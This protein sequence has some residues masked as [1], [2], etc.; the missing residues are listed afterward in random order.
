[1]SETVHAT[2]V[3]VGASGV[4]IRGPSGAGKS[5][6]AWLLIDQGAILVADDRVHL[7]A[8]HGRLVGTVPGRLAGRLELRGRGILHMPFERSV[9][10]RLAVDLVADADLER[11]PNVGELRAQILGIELARQSVP[12]ASHRALTLIGAALAG[13]PS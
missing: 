2:V 13:L 9:L 5:S 3:L 12:G 4:L 10:L 1:L 11:L 8:C 7:S 6:L